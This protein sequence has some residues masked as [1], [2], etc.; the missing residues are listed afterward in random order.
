MEDR[1]Q[2]YRDHLGL[3]Q[4]LLKALIKGGVRT[5]KAQQEQ[6]DPDLYYE[7]KSHILYGNGV[8]TLI[9]MGE[10]VFHQKYYAASINK[11]SP[12]IMSIVQQTL[13]NA[14][15]KYGSIESLLEEAPNLSDH[16]QLIYDSCELHQY[17]M[18]RRKDNWEQDTRPASII[19]D[20]L[21]Y[22][23]ELIESDGKQ[24]LTPEENE[25]IFAVYRSITNH[26]VTREFFEVSE[27]VELKFQEPIYF[28]FRG[29]ECKM[30]PDWYIIN[31]NVKTIQPFDLKTTRNAAANF[32]W[33]VK[34]Y[35]YDFQAAWYTIGFKE[36]YMKDGYTILP[37]KFMVETTERDAQGQ[38]CV[39]TCSPDM[40]SFATHGRP[41]M[42]EH[43][44]PEAYVDVSAAV[45]KEHL[46][47][48]VP[49]VKEILGVHQALDLYDWHLEHGFETDRIIIENQNQ[50]IMSHDE[51]LFL[52]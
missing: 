10:E 5:F 29:H 28:M 17:Y 40:M 13:E 43:F 50:F 48:S 26:P 9:T 22:W 11:P 35:R 25:V 45:D 21:Y 6:D 20:G 39:F 37:F 27:G 16:T 49:V 2:E 23:K 8:D 51:L 34:N 42:Y 44:R 14:K 7:E 31:H 36:T 30:L 18:T 15:I 19:K 38:P 24:I 12:A 1:I 4:S 46:V 3:N 33:D 47:Y 41:K 52:K 32:L